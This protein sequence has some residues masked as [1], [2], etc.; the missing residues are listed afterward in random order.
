MIYK[1]WKY[2]KLVFIYILDFD[3]VMIDNTTLLLELNGCEKVE[4]D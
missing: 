1:E 2:S 4:E 3:E